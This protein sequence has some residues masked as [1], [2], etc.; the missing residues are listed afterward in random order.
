[1]WRNAGMVRWLYVCTAQR[2]WPDWLGKDGDWGLKASWNNGLGSPLCCLGMS[3]FV[4][5]RD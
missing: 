3:F 1:M 2:M 4:C 5:P